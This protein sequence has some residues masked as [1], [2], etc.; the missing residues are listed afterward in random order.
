M[1]SGVE[2]RIESEMR[3]EPQINA[4]GCSLPED[5]MFQLSSE[6]FSNWKS[7]F[8]TSNDKVNYMVSKNAI[9]LTKPIRFG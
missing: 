6:E 4:D 9:P 7:Q 1:K 2:I 5:F 3:N 8:V